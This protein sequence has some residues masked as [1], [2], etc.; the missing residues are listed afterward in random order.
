MTISNNKQIRPIHFHSA[1]A[2]RVAIQLGQIRR[3][4][5]V[6]FLRKSVPAE[7]AV[8]AALS[9]A[10]TNATQRANAGHSTPA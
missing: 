5:N 4:G 1:P 8:R 6:P 9:G 2:V 3:N 10:S 7:M